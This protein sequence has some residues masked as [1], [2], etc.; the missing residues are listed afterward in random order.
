MLAVGFSINSKAYIG[1]GYLN[2]VDYQDFWEYD[3]ISDIWTQ[4][5]DFGGGPRESA[6]GFSINSRGYVGTGGSHQGIWK[7]FW[8]YNPTLNTWTQKADCGTIGRVW[9]VGFSVNSKGYIGTGLLSNPVWLESNDFWE[10]DPVLDTWTQKADFGGIPRENAVGFSISSKGYIGSGASPDYPYLSNY[11]QDFWE[12]DPGSDTWT[13]KADVP[14]SLNSAVGFS[15]GTKGYIG[16]GAST[17]AIMNTFW[18]FN[19]LTNSWSQKATFSGSARAMS[20]GFSIGN[21]GYIGTGYNNNTFFSDFWMYTPTCDA[22]PAPTNTTP[23]GNL[24]ICSGLSTTLYASGTGTLGWYTAATGGTWLGGGSTY[25]TPVLN[26]PAAYYVQDSTCGPS[27]TR[28]AISVIVNSRPVPSLSGPSPVCQGAAGNI[29]TTQ[30]GMTNYTWTV[31]GGSV[32]AGGSSSD[33]S[34]TITWTTAGSQSVSV[35]YY[36]ANNCTSDPTV[37]GVTVYPALTASISGNG[38]PVCPGTSPGTYTVNPSGGTGSYTY[39]WYKDG[40]STGITTLTYAPGP[41]SAATTITCDVTSGPCATIT[42]Q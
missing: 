16:T 29:Y 3:P 37:K 1:T 41:I 6:V 20:V 10:Y 11:D 25:A 17:G 28:T 33:N 30:A 35:S 36:N 34:V 13:R 19:P 27:A 15:I 9:A 23:A 8:E 32:T 18:E 4:K 14:V 22:P 31:A 26:N 7:D 24:V 5:A 12:F 21:H 39:L 2:N 42:A 40:I 38:G